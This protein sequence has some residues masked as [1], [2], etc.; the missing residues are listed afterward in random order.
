MLVLDIEIQ[1]FDIVL[2]DDENVNK[3][4]YA[5]DVVDDGDKTL[6]Y[7]ILHWMVNSERKWYSYTGLYLVWV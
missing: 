4:L 1:L 3:W 6:I 7:L 5:H 2:V